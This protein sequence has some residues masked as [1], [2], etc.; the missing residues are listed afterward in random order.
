MTYDLY[1]DDC[2]TVM[3]SLKSRSVDLVLTDPPYGTTQNEWDAVVPIDQMWEQLK[4]IVTHKGVIVMTATQPF[5]SVLVASN[6]SMFRYEWI[7]LKSNITNA[8]N[9]HVMPMRRHEQ[10]LVFSRLKPNATTYN[11]QGLIDLRDPFRDNITHRR[12]SSNVGRLKAQ[13]HLQYQKGWPNDVLKIPSVGKT[14]HPT[15][16][17]VALMDYLIKTYSNEGDLVLDFSMG[18]GTTGVACM[19]SGR[20]FIGIDNDTEHGYFDIASKRIKDACDEV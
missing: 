1:N 16:K 8:L 15:Q 18:S 19:R 9:S 4:R 17:P 3:S 6:L 14:I 2:I 12:Q 20:R 5:S 11:A 13:I 7:W 10:V